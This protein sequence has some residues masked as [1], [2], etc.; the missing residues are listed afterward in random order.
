MKTSTLVFTQ[1]MLMIPHHWENWISR[2][3]VQSYCGL[4]P[5]GYSVGLAPR[6][7]FSN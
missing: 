2:Y 4:V 6:G 5:A 7:H 3:Q 1:G